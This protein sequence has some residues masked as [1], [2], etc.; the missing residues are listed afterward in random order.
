MDEDDVE[1]T[2]V[3]CEA[4]MN[5][6]DVAIAVLHPVKGLLMGAVNAV[7]HLQGLLGLHSGYLDTKHEKKQF[8][9]EAHDE[10]T[11]MTNG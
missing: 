6:A 10:M 2:P 1:I 9:K 8:S 11:R 5:R 3:R 4:R 7:D